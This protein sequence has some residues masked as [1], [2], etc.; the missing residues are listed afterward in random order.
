[1]IPHPE[2]DPR[3]SQLTLPSVSENSRVNLWSYQELLGNI[4]F[5]K[6]LILILRHHCYITISF[7]GTCKVKGYI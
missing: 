3:V 5:F 1:M 4:Y 2:Y 6:K 7:G